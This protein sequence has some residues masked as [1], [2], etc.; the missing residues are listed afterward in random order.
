LLEAQNIK[1]F[2]QGRG[3]GCGTHGIGFQ[4]PAEK[5]V[6]SP[7]KAFPATMHPGQKYFLEKV[8]TAVVK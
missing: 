2:L 5:K 8:E 6:E 3:S 4:T 1:K 7:K